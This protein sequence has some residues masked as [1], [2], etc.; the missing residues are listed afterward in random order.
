[1]RLRSFN[2]GRLLDDGISPIAHYQFVACRLISS[3]WNYEYW[4]RLHGL[5]EGQIYLVQFIS[6]HKLAK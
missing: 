5:H 2:N 3:I 1:M 4:S 6:N